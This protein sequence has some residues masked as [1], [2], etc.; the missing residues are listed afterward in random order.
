[1]KTI[2][3]LHLSRAAAELVDVPVSLMA[4]ASHLAHA[5]GVS[6]AVATNWVRAQ[7]ARRLATFSIVRSA[8]AA[9]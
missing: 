6:L 8:P 2:L 3:A 9:Q 4:A 5:A 1:M 7:I